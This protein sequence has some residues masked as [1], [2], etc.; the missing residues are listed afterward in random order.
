MKLLDAAAFLSSAGIESPEI[1]ARELFYAF[2]GYD[3][4]LILTKNLEMDDDVLNP[5]L[6]RRADG[7]PLQYIVGEVAFY[8]E[9]YKV[10]P[11][12]LIPRPDTEHLVDYA[13]KN[14]ESGSVF[15][16]LCTG[17]GCVGISTL[18][19]TKDTR[20]IA[21]DISEAALSLAEQ[22]ARINGV[23]ERFR[24]ALGDARDKSFA[25][26]LFDGKLDAV[27]SNPPYIERAVY[28]TLSREVKR[29][30]SLALCADLEGLEFYIKMTPIYKELIKPSGF[31]AYEI[32]YDQAKALKKIAEENKMTAKIIKDYS[33][34]D[35]V[36]V[37]RRPS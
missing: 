28:K 25:L 3:R 4:G 5:L 19:N 1:E 16:D 7:E 30:P 37:L 32:G 36:A 14:L 24:A 8:N 17:S 20:C 22:N 6:R 2:G 18:K 10:N 31:I 35:R 26:S 34:N 11:S 13:V 15:L 23:S 27:L 21:V 29:E 33:G 9:I 12:V